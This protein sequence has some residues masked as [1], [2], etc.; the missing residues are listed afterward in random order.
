MKCLIIFILLSTATSTLIAGG[1]AKRSPPPQAFSACSEVAIGDACSFQGKHR[2][3]EGSCMMKQ[4]KSVCVP[5]HHQCAK[6]C[7]KMPRQSNKKDTNDIGFTQT[8]GVHKSC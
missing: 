6:D 7:E 3:V 2:L 1:F 5:A 8:K 4:Q